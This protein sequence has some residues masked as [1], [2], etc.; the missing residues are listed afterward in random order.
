M[1]ASVTTQ[2]RAAPSADGGAQPSEDFAL[3]P[4]VD[5]TENAN[6]ITLVAD[7]PGVP[8]DRLEIKVDA[9]TLI[10]EA[11]IALPTPEQMS[12]QHAEVQVTRY[13][14]LFALSKELDADKIDAEFKD[15]VLTLHIPKAENAKPRRVTVQ[16]H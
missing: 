8:K 1:Q 2:D 9:D 3:V 12:A 6:G 10:V 11:E 7:L 16:A 15:G 13:R 5:V 14:R 4:A